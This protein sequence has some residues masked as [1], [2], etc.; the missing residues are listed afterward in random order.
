MKIAFQT[1]Q[2]DVRGACV[3]LYDY[4][5]YYELLLGGTSIII[6]RKIAPHDEEGMYKFSKRFEVRFY[7]DISDIDYHISD[8]DIFYSIKYGKNNGIISKKI[9]N[10]IHCVFDLSEPHGDVYAAVSQT[11]ARKYG[12]EL[13]VPHMIGLHPSTTGDNLRKK[14]NIPENAVVFGRH[15]GQDTFDLQFARSAIIHAVYDYQHLYFIF[16]NTPRFIDHPRVIHLNKIIDFDEKNRF[17][18]TCDAHL[19]CGSLGHT[20]GLSMGEFS[21]NNR[22][23]IA[24]KGDVWNTA[25]YD[26][27]KDNAIYFTNEDELYQILITFDPKEWKNKDNNC[28]RDYSPE[29]VM[30][31]FKDVFIQ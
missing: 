1:D 14:L 26:I 23:I 12:K 2:L 27:L 8:C 20:F 9:K 6:T 18:M 13:F 25:H 31:I 19:E 30:K 29:K 3:S 21:V 4:A 11:L 15:G 17:I 22:P 16:V 24:Y 10:C 7:D 28:Y 5:H